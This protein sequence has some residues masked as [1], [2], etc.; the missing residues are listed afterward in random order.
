M[1][2]CLRETT[3]R[4]EIRLAWMFF[5]SDRPKQSAFLVEDRDRIAIVRTREIENEIV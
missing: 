5:R 3:A 4:E 1:D 2:R